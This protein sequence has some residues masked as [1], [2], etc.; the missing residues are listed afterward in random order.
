MNYYGL[1][2]R[3]NYDGSQSESITPIA[4]NLQLNEGMESSFEP[5]TPVDIKVTSVSLDTIAVVLY[6]CFLCAMT[7][8]QQGFYS[9][10]NSV[11]EFKQ[12]DPVVQFNE[13]VSKAGVRQYLLAYGDYEDTQN[14]T[15]PKMVLLGTDAA[16]TISCRPTMLM[17]IIIVVLL[18][19][20]WL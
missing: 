17:L 11:E 4:V 12:N 1:Y 20:L 15:M 3:R 18:L 14:I 2:L 9:T 10:I 7:Q 16:T 8:Q 6:L 19:Q 5:D 13:Y